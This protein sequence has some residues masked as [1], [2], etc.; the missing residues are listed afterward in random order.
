L[1]INVIESFIESL[2]VDDD[3]GGVSIV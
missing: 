1:E 2:L 3:D